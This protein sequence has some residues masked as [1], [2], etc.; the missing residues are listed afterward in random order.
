MI[1]EIS[2]GGI[3]HKFISNTMIT[4]ISTGGIYHKFVPNTI[5]TEISRGGYIIN[6]YHNRCP[7]LNYSTDRQDI[8]EV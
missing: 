8:V 2:R 4:E 1:T 3:Y 6:L 7:F 5:I